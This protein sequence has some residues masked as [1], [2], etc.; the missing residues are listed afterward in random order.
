M[1]EPPLSRDAFAPLRGAE[2]IVLTTYRRSGVAVPTTV[3]F[4]DTGGALYLTTA[5]ESGKVK[6]L[7]ANPAVLVAPSDRLG[8]VQGP[9]LPGR[10]RMLEPHEHDAAIAAL[11]RKY[12]EQYTALTAQMDAGRPAGGRT[13]VIITP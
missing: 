7:R 4:A 9:A 10:A 11:R 12:G 13:Y 6:R 1:T 2:F 8:N 5:A 3:W